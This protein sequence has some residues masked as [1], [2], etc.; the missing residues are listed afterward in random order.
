VQTIWV[1]GDQPFAE[2][3]MARAVRVLVEVVDG[4]YPG[5]TPIVDWKPQSSSEPYAT[6]DRSFGQ[7]LPHG[8]PVQVLA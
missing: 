4:G 7:I 6:E 8:G 3:F 5:A 2:A 1:G